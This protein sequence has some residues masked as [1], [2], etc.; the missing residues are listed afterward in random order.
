MAVSSSRFQA[1]CQSV[2]SHVAGP[3]ADG[4]IHVSIFTQMP[5]TSVTPEMARRD[6]HAGLAAVATVEAADP[7]LTKLFEQFGVVFEYVYDYETGAVKIGD[8]AREGTV[9]ML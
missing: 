8:V 7:R 5:A 3:A 9:T 2:C 4:R 6:A 1:R